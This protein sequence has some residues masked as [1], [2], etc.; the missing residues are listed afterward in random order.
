M[1]IEIWTRDKE[2]DSVHRQQRR[3]Q[4]IAWHMTC[5]IAVAEC[6]MEITQWMRTHFDAWSRVQSIKA[7]KAQ[8]LGPYMGTANLEHSFFT[9]LQTG[10]QRAWPGTATRL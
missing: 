1:I 4:N 10:S 7:G 9:F 6:L 5:F 3:I 8:W 2:K